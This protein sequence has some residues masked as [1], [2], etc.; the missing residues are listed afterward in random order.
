MFKTLRKTE[1]FELMV[2]FLVQGAAMAVWVVPLGVILDVHGMHSIKPFAF[3][4]GSL[5]AFVSPLLFGAMADRHVPPAKVLRWL[6]LATAFMI[7]IV[8]TAIKFNS[9]EWLVLALIQMMALASA[10]MLSI[11]SAVVFARLADPKEFAAMRVMMTIGWVTGCILA[12]LFNL[13]TSAFAGYV[14]AVIWLI[15]AAYTFFLPQQEMPKSAENL[16]WHE[17]LGLD[18]LVLLKNPDHRV[19][20]LMTTLVSI[21]IAGFYP[22]APVNLR[23]LGFVHSSAW[24]SLAQTTEAI[25]IFSMSW[26]LLKWR[27]KWI[28]TFGLAFA[29]ARFVFSA[30]NTKT[31]LLI[32]IALHGAS[33]AFISITAQIYLD[34]RI[35]PSWRARSQ[36]LLTLMNNGFG[37]LI[38]YLGTGWWFNACT[39]PAGTQWNYFWGGCAAVAVGAMAYFLTA[40]RGQSSE[41]PRGQDPGNQ[42]V[43]VRVK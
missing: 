41:R 11:T 10:P 4:T 5:A 18:A 38:G 12:S 1:Y 15:L 22:Y 40:Y 6:A 13:D 24:M 37:F 27:M 7:S 34:Q 3:A 35:E 32:G 20:F 16:S 25:A 14:S 39:H 29:V 9:N 42:P 31:C 2:L 23:D 43:S 26:L 36:A 33:F 17:R 19:I 28:F 30:I 21:P 8:A